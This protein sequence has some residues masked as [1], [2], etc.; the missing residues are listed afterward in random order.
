MEQAETEERDRD[1][2]QALQRHLQRAEI[3]TSG[4]Q[5]T[6]KVYE[7]EARYVPDKRNDRFKDHLQISLCPTV[8]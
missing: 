6:D 3:H 5:A 2:R 1:V 7:G 8:R 4:R